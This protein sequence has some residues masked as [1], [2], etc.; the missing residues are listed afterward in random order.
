VKLLFKIWVNKGSNDL[1]SGSD[2][3]VFNLFDKTNK[4]NVKTDVEQLWRR[5]G[6]QSVPDISEDLLFIAISLFCADKRIPRT[7]YWT[8]EIKI[9]IPVLE[10]GTWNEVKMEL[11]KALGFL[12]GDK[13]VFEFRKTDN[14][15]RSNKQNTKYKVV[16]KKDY[17]SVCLFSGG[18]DSFCGAISLLERKE[19]T[20]FIGF[21][22]HNLL[23]SRQELLFDAL[24]NA[25]PSVNKELLL[26]NVNPFAPLLY[27]GEKRNYGIESSSRSRSFLFLAGA[28]VVASIIG[29]GTP[30]YIPENG[31]IGINVPL[32]DSRNGSCSTRTTHPFFIKSLNTILNKVGLNHKIENF[33]WNKSKGEI[34]E[35]HMDKKVFKDFAQ[36]TLSCS[37]PCLCRYDKVQPPTNCG[38]CY[39]CLIRRASLNCIGDD[40][41]DYNEHYILNKEFIQKYN[42]LQGKASDLKAVLFSIRRYLQHKEDKQYIR[43]LLV[44]QGPLTIEEVDAYERLYRKS[45]DELLAMI[46]REDQK[47]KGGLLNY[48]GLE[49]LLKCHG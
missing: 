46:I 24:N 25:Y 41:T 33:Y 17:N 13:W 8:R 48:I 4:S 29:E 1:S 36:K 42:N 6:I 35:L 12:S 18:L 37:H 43:S 27:N 39:P 2:F 19:S 11:E 22:E 20:C 32:T 30:V 16:D 47:N 45:M 21:R 28:I 49:D 3:L 7:E 31:F 23:T 38:Y 40:N 9:C 44:R 5:F 26:F 15:F 14:K 10:I 34:V